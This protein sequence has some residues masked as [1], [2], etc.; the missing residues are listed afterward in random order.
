MH[1]ESGLSGLICPQNAPRV[2]QDRLAQKVLVLVSRQ[3]IDTTVHAIADQCMG[4]EQCG[5]VPDCFGV[6]KRGRRI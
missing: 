1:E 3:R 2:F 5:D 6:F 4:V